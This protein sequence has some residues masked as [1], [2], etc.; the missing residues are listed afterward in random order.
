MEDRVLLSGVRN[1]E[2]MLREMSRQMGASYR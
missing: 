1:D 2:E